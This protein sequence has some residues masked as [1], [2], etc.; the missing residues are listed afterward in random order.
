LIQLQYVVSGEVAY[1]IKVILA[2]GITI[3]K[4]LKFK[5]KVYINLLFLTDTLSNYIEL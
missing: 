4:I 1:F 2:R 3:L 5:D